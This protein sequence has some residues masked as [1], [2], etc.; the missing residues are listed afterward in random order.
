MTLP[1]P[2]GYPGRGDWLFH[3]VTRD[4]DFTPT[5]E[6][7]LI[8]QSHPEGLATISCRVVDEDASLVFANED[9][10]YAT[11]RGTRIWAGHITVPGET[12]LQEIGPRV[13]ELTGTDY[14]AKLDHAIVRREQ[15]RK[16]EKIR[17]RI[18][19]ILNQLRPSVWTLDGK[20]IDVPD[21][22]VEPYDYYGATIREALQQVAD[23]KRLFFYV[24]LDNVFHMFRTETI[25]A[26][27]SLDNEAPDYVSTFPLYEW[28]RTPD[29]TELANAILVE[30]EHRS[31]ARWSKDAE[32]IT[33]YRRHERFISDTNL[34][35]AQQATNVGERALAQ[36]KDPEDE[37]TC[38]VK[39]PGLRAGMTIGIREAKWDHDFSRIIESVEIHAV[40]PHDEAGEAMLY[41]ELTLVE[42]KPGRGGRGHSPG[43]NRNTR[44]RPGRTADTEPRVLDDFPTDVPAP[45]IT[46][47]TT[48]TS[49]IGQR[50][51]VSRGVDLSG[52]DD[53]PIVTFSPTLAFAQSSIGH[54]PAYE[55]ANTHRGWWE[56]EAWWHYSVPTHPAS[57]AGHRVTLNPMVSPS[58]YALAPGVFLEIVVRDSVPTDIRQGTL[59]GTLPV[60]TTGAVVDIPIGLIP[61]AGGDVWI[62]V[63]AGWQ[64]DYGASATG[65]WTWPYASTATQLDSNGVGYLGR[66][67]RDLAPV[68]QGSAVWLVYSS[69]GGDLGSIA[70][71]TGAPYQ[72]GNAYH[73][74]GSEGSPVYS[75]SAGTLQLTG[76]GAHGWYVLGSRE[77]DDEPVGAWSD[78]AWGTEITFSVSSTDATDTGTR[79]IEITTTGE[80]EKT[81]GTVHL[82]DTTRAE[83]ISVG[84]PDVVQYAPVDI[85]TVDRWRALFD[86]RSGEMRGK[87]FLATTRQPA[88]WLL[89]TT[90]GETEDDAD[91]YAL[92]LRAGADGTPPTIRIHRIRYLPP[93]RPGSRVVRELLGRADGLTKRFY[94]SHA[95]REGSLRIMVN[96]TPIAPE[97]EDPDGLWGQLDWWPTTGATIRATYIVAG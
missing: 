96:G 64:A 63:R 92:W 5:L 33:A 68:L 54:E 94:P 66:S 50:W 52:N 58:G 37:A 29:S 49:A 4:F 26:P 31:R 57:P 61:D 84:G 14:T 22:Y 16:R 93:A 85:S 42:R 82:G 90:M 2:E 12:Q 7:I 27:F 55:G 88:N 1:V 95:F 23:E 35:N 6:S 45:T 19:W 40:D 24:D 34:E 69:A 65:Y 62:G 70:S 78:V 60:A 67:G 51:S 73:D 32:S 89:R 47:G 48:I 53:G 86:S 3:S 17:R 15:K 9:E 39:E 11:F 46:T 81:I 91:R 76:P 8:A 77:D 13:W 36:S 83:G 87:L 59:V 71:P 28:N 97:T 56:R 43:Q 75:V 80:G 10:A 18:R 72:G 38:V 21:Q 30:P 44:T 25:A 74:A 79:A 41:Q 20:E